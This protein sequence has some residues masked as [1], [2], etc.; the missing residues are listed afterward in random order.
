MMPF[1]AL[2]PAVAAL[3]WTTLSVD[4][5]DLT[6][7]QIY[8]QAAPGVVV[9]VGTEERGKGG[10][11]GTGAIIDS[12]GL[13]FTNAH[14]VVDKDTGKP[15]G[16]LL[17]VLKPD[18]VTGQPEKD[19]AK[20]FKARV[21]AVNRELDLAALRFDPGAVKPRVLSL[22]NPDHIQ[23]GDW[24]AA[25]GHPEQG[26]LWTF[27]TGVV[28]AEF[29]DFQSTKGKHVFQTEI[30]MNRGNSGGP[31]IDVNGNVVGVNTSIARL[32]PDGLPITSISFSVKSNVLKQWLGEQGLRV[33]YAE[34]S[35]VAP[36][37]LASAATP[38][39]SAPPAAVVPSMPTEPPMAQAP[40]AAPSPAKPA[41]P[42]VPPV[43]PT[44][45]APPP[46]PP[47]PKPEPPKVADTPP[48][49]PKPASPSPSAEAQKPAQAPA[50]PTPKIVETPQ[51]TPSPSPTP[52]AAEAPQ[53]VQPPTADKPVKASPA[54][55]A[56]DPK[57]F[58]TKA[59]PYDP[60]R[61]VDDIRRLDTEMEDLAEE[62]RKKFRSR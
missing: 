1:R 18:R 41:A 46:P 14:V 30:G 28:S 33:A 34:P 22:S 39:A 26:G 40:A 9:V 32:A 53:T 52:K 57:P 35:A 6:P 54:K 31:L 19:Y 44:V 10:S 49:S 62:M 3:V 55:P 50:A 25:I 47:T 20:R 15:F 43:P 2:A 17:I 42:S 38:G 11:T 48:A 12:Q 45:T 51:A 56:P 61:L 5:A 60:E 29:E 4:A 24:V 58:K 59:R 13:V 8:E 36:V 27:T 21:V 7:R 23:I 16:Q 37:P